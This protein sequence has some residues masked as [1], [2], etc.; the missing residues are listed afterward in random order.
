[1][2][3][4]GDCIGPHNIILKERTVKN[5]SGKW[6][7][8]FDCP[9]CGQEFEAC[10][11]DISS[12]KT[13]SCGCAYKEDRIKIH[14]LTG[15][16]FG[17]LTALYPTEQRK[18]RKVVWHCKCKCGNE[19]DVPSNSLVTG[20]TKSCGCSHSIQASKIQ[21]ILQSLKID[22][23]TE[24]TFKDLY[25][26]NINNKLRFD[27]AIMENNNLVGLIEYDGELHYK[28]SNNGWDTE[29]RYVILKENDLR[30][31]NYCKQHNIPIRRISYLD[32]DKINKEYIINLIKDMK[33]ELS[34]K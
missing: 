30:K 34:N 12:G 9:R 15:Q 18:Y 4:I 14:D 29:K 13:R 8:L 21:N 26:K 33:N 5:N 23:Q 28:F 31:D 22:F 19:I 11:G 32:K 16:E 1:M 24:Y 10:I 27:F 7:G 17:L 25:T 2:Y 20:N 6:K 3:K